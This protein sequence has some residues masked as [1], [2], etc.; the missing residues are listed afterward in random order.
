MNKNMKLDIGLLA[1]RIALGLYLLLAGVGK[2]QGELN[3]G[4]GSFYNSSFKGLQPDWLPAF[5]G[6]PYGYALPWL[7]VIVGALLIVGF[8]GHLA[9]L[10]GLLMITSFTI[11]LAM[12]NNSI[13]AQGADAA[14]P[15][16][17]NYIQIAGY[18]LLTL[19]GCGNMGIDKAVFGKNKSK[20]G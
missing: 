7:E 13:V 10:I 5:L 17:T 1:L 16:H 6:A 9:A 20:K 14:G 15:Y 19:V 2:V 3:N 12:A 18:L 11:A 4:I 8:L